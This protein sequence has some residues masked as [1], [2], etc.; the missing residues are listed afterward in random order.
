MVEIFPVNPDLIRFTHS[1]IR[2]Y[3]SGCGKSIEQSLQEIREGNV[4][5]E[6]IP[7]ITVIEIENEYF[8][9]NN[10]RLFMFKLLKKE[11]YLP[12]G[13]IRAYKKPGLERERRKYTPE[14]CSLYAV[15]MKSATIA[16]EFSSDKCASSMNGSRLEISKDSNTF[17]ASSHGRLMNAEV[18]QSL[19]GLQ[20]LMD[21]GKK[22]AVL[23]QIDEWIMNGLIN[24]L[25][26]LQYIK[27]KLKL[28]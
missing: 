12:S 26:D 6:D 15:L 19:H 10:R 14:N 16:E 5:V 3:F 27:W 18:V 21:K 13:T 4:A 1:R 8:S 9:L 7:L 28:S 20:K 22:R 17:N 2:P 11:G 24:E 25:E 23:S